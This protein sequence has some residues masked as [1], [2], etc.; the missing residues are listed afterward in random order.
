MAMMHFITA[1][2]IDFIALDAPERAVELC[3]CRCSSDYEWNL[4]IQHAQSSFFLSLLF[5]QKLLF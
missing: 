2:R 5:G 4:A 1:P 3:S